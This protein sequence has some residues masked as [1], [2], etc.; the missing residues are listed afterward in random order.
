MGSNVAAL[1][2]NSSLQFL[3]DCYNSNHMCL[4]R[5]RDIKYMVDSNL[6]LQEL[7]EPSNLDAKVEEI[8]KGSTSSI[9]KK[10]KYGKKQPIEM[11]SSLKRVKENT[12]VQSEKKKKIRAARRR[13]STITCRE[14]Y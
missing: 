9:P 8:A 14:G 3:L 6:P 5:A 7:V 11:A 10:G 2:L 1:I 12:K 4:I 13:T